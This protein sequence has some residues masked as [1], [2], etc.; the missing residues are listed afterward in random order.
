MADFKDVSKVLDFLAP[1]LILGTLIKFYENMDVS[2]AREGESSLKVDSFPDLDW[3]M[4]VY[5]I[6][7][8][9]DSGK[10]SGWK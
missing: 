8:M 9:S 6:L 7:R 4:Q 3:R 1:N 10:W 2:I 5:I